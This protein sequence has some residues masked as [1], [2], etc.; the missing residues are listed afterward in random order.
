MNEVFK[1]NAPD[2]FEISKTS[3]AE[4]DDDDENENDDHNTITNTRPFVDEL[5]RSG[6]SVHVLVD[7]YIEKYESTSMMIGIDRS[8]MFMMEVFK[9][10]LLWTLIPNCFLKEFYMLYPEL[11]KFNFI[12]AFTR[13]FT[14]WAITLK[15]R[16]KDGT[17]VENKVNDTNFQTLVD[18][19]TLLNKML[20]N[21]HEMSRCFSPMLVASGIFKWIDTKNE[22]PWDRYHFELMGDNNAYVQGPISMRGTSLQNA[23]SGYIRVH[24]DLNEDN[25]FKNLNI[26]LIYNDRHPFSVYQND[27]RVPMSL[28]SAHCGFSA[29]DYFGMEVRTKISGSKPFSPKVLVKFFKFDSTILYFASDEIKDED[30]DGKEYVEVNENP[31]EPYMKQIEAILQ[32]NFSYPI[33]SESVKDCESVKSCLRINQRLVKGISSSTAP[34]MLL[35]N[36]K[37]LVLDQFARFSAPASAR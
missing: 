29:T 19:Q 28:L 34:L 13:N 17:M 30:F 6:L 36:M 27:L 2:F 16:K 12:E 14:T 33:T 10:P 25:S 15:V 22:D 4:N 37:D 5:V 21:K 20:L 9:R 11:A 23:G 31:G 24:F 26:R 8:T 1:I 32:N 18:G 7:E 3:P 35:N